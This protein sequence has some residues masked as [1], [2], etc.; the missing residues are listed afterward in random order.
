VYVTN[1]ALAFGV[2]LL[3]G[4]SDKDTSSD[5]DSAGEGGEGA[6]GTAGGAGGSS[7]AAG[8]GGSKSTEGGRSATGGTAGGSA[9]GAGR[10]PSGGSGGMT[11]TGGMSNASGGAFDPGGSGGDAGDGG[12]TAGR[13]TFD[14]TSG[15]R[16]EHVD[17][18]EAALAA[19]TGDFD[20]DGD[21]DLAVVEYGQSAPGRYGVAWGSP[22][23]FA[24]VAWTEVPV[25]GQYIAFADFNEDGHGD[26]LLSGPRSGGTNNEVGAAVFFGDGG[27]EFAPF[28]PEAF[29]TLVAA[30]AV[31][32]F[33]TD[34]HLDL[35]TARSDAFG[36]CT[37]LGNGAFNAYESKYLVEDP[38]FSNGGNNT[39]LGVGDVDENGTLD[40]V[41]PLSSQGF[42]EL[43]VLH[44][45][46]AGDFTLGERK[47]IDTGE[48]V[49]LHLDGD[50]HIDMV[51]AA[52]GLVNTWLGDGTGAFES[53]TGLLPE[54]AEGPQYVAGG[55]FDG[56]G[57]ADFVTYNYDTADFSVLLGTG[58][59]HFEPVRSIPA[60]EYGAFEL[61]LDDLDH[62]GNDDIVHATTDGVDVYYG[63]CDGS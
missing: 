33:D 60:K 57:R 2:A 25:L 44:V 28:A 13:G 20:D 10:S 47:F 58:D 56:D 11:S 19:A 23:G 15:C 24:P 26:F 45:D 18:L 50:D 3:A 40:V 41:V 42:G 43:Q 32:D 27:R 6:V 46:E 49:L 1:V 62:D 14:E 8:K 35:L 7:A 29:T 17:V 21:V 52:D 38:L 5:D 48:P 9:A 34:G 4:C 37:G 22:S 36:L 30:S 16:Y 63:P 31:G 53:V 12:S 59:G 51:A 55:D 39:W 54:T 61:L